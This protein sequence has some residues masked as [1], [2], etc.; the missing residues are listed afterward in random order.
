[1]YEAND[2]YVDVDNDDD[3]GDDDD[4]DISMA[5]RD[6]FQLLISF[7]ISIDGQKVQTSNENWLD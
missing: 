1:M 3:V 6:G 2:V 5:H 4:D 7:V